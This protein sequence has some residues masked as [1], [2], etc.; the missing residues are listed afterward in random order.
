[1]KLHRA[2]FYLV[3]PFLVLSSKSFAQE[4]NQ[5]LASVYVYNFTKYIEWPQNRKSGD[6]VIGIYGNSSTFDEFKKII[7]TKKVGKQPIALKKTSSVGDLDQFNLIYIPLSESKN[8]KLISDALNGKP[9]LIVSEKPGAA[10][11][12]ASINLFLDEDDDF[13]TK[14]E[15]N[16]KTMEKNGLIISNQLLQL[17]EKVNE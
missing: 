17:A 10:K 15:M 6:F 1:M 3:L 12:G 7:S 16:K 5:K 8:I 14:F 9:V 2:I 4:L 13:K 11:K